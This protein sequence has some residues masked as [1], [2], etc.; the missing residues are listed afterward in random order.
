[1]REENFRM[2]EDGKRYVKRVEPVHMGILPI[3][4]SYREFWFPCS[5]RDSD[6]Q[7]LK[8]VLFGW[9]GYHRFGEGKWLIGLFYLC[10]CGCF[11]VFY[12]Y[13]LL[14]MILGN[15]WYTKVTYE[16]GEEGIVRQKRKFY[17]APLQKKRRAFL[18]LMMAVLLCLFLI[19]FL[20]G[21]LIQRVLT[22]CA[23]I[24]DQ[25]TI[26]DSI[27]DSLFHLQEG[28]AI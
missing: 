13:D 15:Y 18:L 20:Y 4:M 3:T 11:G 9:F 17:Y 7:Y 28:G 19:Y 21:P 16:E 8:T 12:L 14:E 22:L 27:R 23:T 24:I 1:M 26:G 25:G 10:T 2:D 6:A 5:D